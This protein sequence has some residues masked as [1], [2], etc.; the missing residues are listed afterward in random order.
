MQTDELTQYFSGPAGFLGPV[1]LKPTPSRWKTPDGGVDKS[2]E[3]RKNLVAGANKL[4]Y[5]LPT[6]AGR[7]FL[8]LAAI[9]A[10]VNEGRK[11]SVD[12]CAGSS[13]LASSRDRPHLQARYNTREH[14]AKVLD[15]NGKEV[16]PIMGSYGIGIERILTAAIE[17]SND[18][19]GFW[20]RPRCAFHRGGDGDKHRRCSAEG[21]RRSACCGA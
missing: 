15:P 16:T 6:C 21:D 12:G 1:G 3:G 7:D 20:L 11:L 19:N 10:S 9:S 18:K 14:G 5:H 13:L 2:L 17:Q 4:D 8:D